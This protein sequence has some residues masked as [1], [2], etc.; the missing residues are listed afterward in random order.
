MLDRGKPV[1]LTKSFC[2]GS[3]HEAFTPVSRKPE[4]RC[5]QLFAI[6]KGRHSDECWRTEPVRLTT[7]VNRPP[8]G[9]ERRFTPIDLRS[10]II[11]MGLLDLSHARLLQDSNE[12]KLNDESGSSR[13]GD[14]NMKQRNKACLS[15]VNGVLALC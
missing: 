1:R 4:I 15:V 5:G 11:G 6:P 10:I 7:F 3:F 8:F 12:R 14:I 13:S 9:R 2:I